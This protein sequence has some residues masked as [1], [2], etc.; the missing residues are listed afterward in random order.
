MPRG[1][2]PRAHTPLKI[3][4]PF[5]QDFTQFV[6]IATNDT[7]TG[8]CVEVFRAAV[9]LLPY[10]LDFEFVPYGVGNQSLSYTDMLRLVA[11][12]TFDGAVG[13]ITITQ[14]RQQL[15]QFTQ[16]VQSASLSMAVA[17][18]PTS[19]GA[20]SFL[21]PF[22]LTM[23][24]V[25]LASTAFTVVAVW[26]LEKNQNE[27]FYANGKLSSQIIDSVWYA[28]TT[29][30][31]AQDKPIQTTMGRLAM[32]CWLFLVLI[33]TAS[34]TASLSSILTVQ[35]LA[36][37]P[38]SLSVAISLKL[39]LGYHEGS[40]TYNYL[41]AIGI[42]ASVLFPLKSMAEFADAL[43]S[44]KVKAVI[45]EAPYLDVFNSRF[46]SYTRVKEQLST[47]NWG[48]A[49]HKDMRVP[50]D[51]SIAISKLAQSGQL[52][53]MHDFWIKG[54][55]SCSLGPS[56]SSTSLG[57]ENFWTLFVIYSAVAVL[58]CLVYC[59]MSAYT[60]Y[61]ILSYCRK[62]EKELKE[63]LEGGKAGSSRKGRAEEGSTEGSKGA[64]EGGAGGVWGNVRSGLQTMME[65]NFFHALLVGLGWKDPPDVHSALVTNQLQHIDFDSYGAAAGYGGGGAGGYGV[66]AGFN[67]G[68]PGEEG[69]I[70]GVFARV[71]SMGGMRSFK[72]AEGS[73]STSTSRLVRRLRSFGE[74]GE[75]GGAAFDRAGSM[76]GRSFKHADRP[77]SSGSG[78]L[79][80]S[81]SLKRRF[82]RGSASQGG[83]FKST[84]SFKA[85]L[86]RK[87][88]SFQQSNLGKEGER[89]AREAREER[90][91]IESTSVKRAASFRA[92]S[93]RSASFK[94]SEAFQ[95]G[96]V[97]RAGG[98][99]SASVPGGEVIREATGERE[100]QRQEYGQEG[101]AKQF[102]RPG[103]GGTG[104]SGGSRDRDGTGSLGAGA[105]L[106][107]SG[108]L[109]KTGSFK[110]SGSALRAPS[111]KRPTSSREE[112]RERD[113]S[114]I[115]ER[116]PQPP[117]QHQGPILK[118]EGL[119]K[120]LVS[121]KGAEAGSSTGGGSE[122][123]S[124]GGVE[125]GAG[126]GSGG[127]GARGGGGG[128]GQGGGGQTR[129]DIKFGGSARGKFE[130][131]PV[132][133]STSWG[134]KGALSTLLSTAAL[135]RAQSERRERGGGQY[136]RVS[137]ALSTL[138]S[139]AALDKHPQSAERGITLDLG[140]SAFQ[141]IRL[142]RQSLTLLSSLPQSLY[143]SLAFPF[144]H[145]DLSPPHT[146]SSMDSLSLPSTSS[147]QVDVPPS[148]AH[149]LPYD[150]IQFTLV[151]C[152]G[153]ASLIRTIIGGPS[154]RYLL[155]VYG[156]LF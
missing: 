90:E 1:W 57:P 58:C 112:G 46:C 80:S 150:K 143:H 85:D 137:R 4:V 148:L 100:Q 138:L 105:G 16:P 41:L 102:V 62:L 94:Q 38:D 128:G 70:A 33:V 125:R 76:G 40:F 139:T 42:P 21:S 13:D 110:R 109:S 92:E 18:E 69:G 24:L 61:R 131:G 113:G 63:E 49:F 152:P 74:E 130:G 145:V 153:H 106:A 111:F 27:D 59:A 17:Q 84:T 32:M 81:K 31:F 45:D 12:K 23:W 122:S 55:T 14:E 19:T 26:F 2:F 103:S 66:A 43:G 64:K 123:T 30:V 127:A 56:V 73:T 115:A 25:I 149:E 20:W 142:Q 134:K 156:S 28:L 126:G 141:L 98:F 99:R 155:S 50:Y 71:G 91:S 68:G 146:L 75:R 140:F 151:D 29:I 54:S 133:R 48:F 147:P 37:T 39:P 11:N 124:R 88:Q 132:W 93:M 72:N 120:K 114:G 51:L 47:F 35:N 89:D 121:F 6:Q 86:F 10:T 65:I 77:T 117:Q 129:P 104:G 9:G 154:A 52:Q 83:S 79:K 15:V 8:F 116:Q 135:K 36:A 22:S 101:R 95:G 96:P 82:A 97:A 87:Q 5:K 60:G 107:Q 144:C 118:P 7:I 67:G 44:G 3:A 34:Y 119:F 78:H 136:T 53:S 108:S